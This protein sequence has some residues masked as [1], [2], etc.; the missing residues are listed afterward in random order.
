MQ[1]RAILTIV[2]QQLEQELESTR[3]RGDQTL[4]SFAE[5]L[6]EAKE[7][8]VSKDDE[9]QALNSRLVD[10]QSSLA[11]AHQCTATLQ[12]HIKCL[13]DD[14][15]AHEVELET[16]KDHVR[17]L[18]Q[19]MHAAE[20]KR[21][22]AEEQ[23][24]KE[25][26][27]SKEELRR[28]HQQAERLRNDLNVI[29]Q[30]V[31]DSLEDQSV[32][33][34]AS[35]PERQLGN[36]TEMFCNDAFVHLELDFGV[37]NIQV[38]GLEHSLQ[39]LEEAVR[40]RLESTQSMVSSIQASRQLTN[41]AVPSSAATY[42][43]TEAHLDAIEEDYES[44]DSDS[45][46]S[47]PTASSGASMS[48]RS[49]LA[50]AGVHPFTPPAPAEGTPLRPNLGPH[51]RDALASAAG[52]AV[53]TQLELWGCEYD[54]GFEGSSFDEV[55]EH[56]KSCALRKDN[57]CIADP[58]SEVRV[59]T[60]DI[61]SIGEDEQK[62]RPRTPPPVIEQTRPVS[63][64]VITRRLKREVA[65]SNDG[66]MSVSEES[67]M[68]GED[69]PL[70]PE[71]PRTPTELLN[72]HAW[73]FEM[74][75]TQIPAES[76]FETSRDRV[77]RSLI[78]AKLEKMRM[79]VRARSIELQRQVDLLDLQLADLRPCDRPPLLRDTDYSERCHADQ[80]DGNLSQMDASVQ[81]L[82]TQMNLALQI[83]CSNQQ[84][85]I[86]A[87]KSVTDLAAVVAALRQT[88]SE[89][90][91]E[92]QDLEA[93]ISSLR[94]HEMEMCR[95]RQEEKEEWEATVSS[96]HAQAT[97]DQT[98]ILFMETTL[99][100]GG[101]EAK[102]LTQEV[103]RL[104]TQARSE[105]E[106]RDAYEK[107]CS[108]TLRHMDALKEKMFDDLTDKDLQL[109]AM[110]L[111]ATTQ[112]QGMRQKLSQALSGFDFRLECIG[113]SMHDVQHCLKIEAETEIAQAVEA[114][115]ETESLML[116]LSAMVEELDRELQKACVKTIQHL[117]AARVETL[118]AT[119]WQHEVDRCESQK[120]E[121]RLLQLEYDK[122]ILLEEC[123]VLAAFSKK[124]QTQI[125][126]QRTEGKI[127]QEKEAEQNTERALLCNG[128]VRALNKLSHVFEVDTR[129]IQNDLE[130][131]QQEMQEL[132]EHIKS[133]EERA[134]EDRA[135]I[136]AGNEIVESS[137]VAMI[138]DVQALENSLQ[139]VKLGS[140]LQLLEEEAQ[141][142]QARA[143][144]EG[145]QSVHEAEVGELRSKLQ[146]LQVCADM[147]SLELQE[148]KSEMSGL[149]Q[150]NVRLELAIKAAFEEQ[151]VQSQHFSRQLVCHLCLANRSIAQMCSLHVSCSLQV[152][153]V[154][155]EMTHI[156][157][158]VGYCVP[159]N[160]AS[161]A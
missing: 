29:C 31:Q 161:R 80:I 71:D 123:N 30:E 43:S 99:A 133:L 75:Y 18:K 53:V 112:I 128:L 77:H 56:E 8:I 32:G 104:E 126:E 15:S 25:A 92:K 2:V 19:Q 27:R 124:L 131:Q 38:N 86:L 40:A 97:A 146:A 101:D 51:R 135:L 41:R 13:E 150:E 151:F 34:V 129:S 61:R 136:S 137:L 10:L 22:E 78:T 94:V 81:I 12:G 125:E 117:E 139:H 44:T 134:K 158:G 119:K 90:I 54:C 143:A 111:V 62:L 98:R 127:L 4:S 91:R 154:D 36:I 52:A 121:E 85:N 63:K 84:R 89:S 100:A 65:T 45:G 79:W 68:A 72:E 116:Q 83:E 88:Q 70:E 155:T 87:S 6:G 110:R 156:H 69:Q 93:K 122:S 14:M 55:V 64:C 46:N 107:K 108:E 67:G 17:D 39:Q 145:D 58:E 33:S 138:E 48:W 114:K 5:L 73:Q 141:L 142:K 11:Q 160:A 95:K 147:L 120:A 42:V 23:A 102:A 76:H 50:S 105:R 74:E 115:I 35:S 113:E 26:T 66:G 157:I 132:R 47:P 148:S 82:Q 20:K 24:K 109:S 103:K 7:M 60:L 153:H 144:R 130:V 57:S 28:A 118:V 152:N 49:T 149:Q 159:G 37:I 59:A 106:S 9:I 96:L 16:S 21:L 3:V 1:K 140:S